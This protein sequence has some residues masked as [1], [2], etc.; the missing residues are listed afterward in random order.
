VSP[1]AAPVPAPPAENVTYEVSALAPLPPDPPAVIAG[2]GAPA[3]QAVPALPAPDTTDADNAAP[4]SPSLGPGAADE[5]RAHIRTQANRPGELEDAVRGIGQLFHAS[6]ESVKDPELRRILIRAAGVD[7][8]A[9]KAAF[10]VMSTDMGSDGP[11]LLYDLLLR[12][13]SLA[14][15]AKFKLT[16]FRTRKLFSPELAIAYD[17]RFAPS[18]ESRLGL[19]P[20]ANE[21]GDQRSINVLTALLGNP[22]QCGNPGRPPCQELCESE[23]AVFTR[24]IESIVRRLRASSELPGVA[25]PP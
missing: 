24:S 6:P 23:S 3:D 8:E 12:R 20:R 19:L 18:C 9:S 17:L 10:R 1:A 16:R 14:E 13:P 22:K 7:G 15:R 25:G 2:P 5:L 11:D 4:P 21:V